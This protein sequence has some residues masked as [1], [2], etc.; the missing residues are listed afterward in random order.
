[1]IRLV[2][3]AS[4]LVGCRISLESEDTAALACTVNTKS[5]A[6]VE[7]DSMMRDDLA[8]IEDNVFAPSCIFSGCH[9]G[10]STPQGKIDLRT[11]MSCAHLVNYTSAI[12]PT[13]KLV[14]PNDVE[15]SYLMLLLS[16]VP[17]EMASPPG[18]VPA[19]GLMPLG[20]G[21]LCCQ[22]LDA[23]RRWIEKGAPC[24]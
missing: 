14:I 5:S 15:A 16:D 12:E 2:L 20:A 21:V 4:L 9:N 10:D 23:V 18:R 24:N 11:G 13:R 8:W 3:V 6:C 22:K 1:M 7:A 19:I 17:P